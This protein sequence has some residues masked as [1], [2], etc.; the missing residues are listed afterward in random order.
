MR[1]KQI[2][3]L[4][5]FLLIGGGICPH[6]TAQLYIGN[7][8]ND[9]F[10]SSGN[11]VV[12]DGM[13]LTPSSN[14]TLSNT[15]I[16]KG[17]MAVTG[18]NSAAGITRVYTLS[19]S[20]TFTGTVSV[21]YNDGEL[22]GN[23][24]SQL[25]IAYLK[26]NNAWVTSA[27][28]TDDAVNNIVSDNFSAVSFKSL[29]ATQAGTILPLIVNSFNARVV[30]AAVELTW[31][32]NEST[33]IDHFDIEASSDN[34]AWSTAGTIQPA[35]TDDLQNYNYNDPDLYF[36][37]RYYRLKVVMASQEAYYSRIVALRSSGTAGM[38]VTTAK[39]MLKASFPGWQP[40]RI[41][42]F[43]WQGRLLKTTSLHQPVWQTSMV[44]PGIY[45][46]SAS[47]GNTRMVRKILIH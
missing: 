17:S 18:P 16:T 45:L 38:E 22:N 37:T 32:A 26:P 1:V 33:A 44:Q 41:Q 7:A 10:I 29:T 25:Q 11:S 46:L 15:Q 5:V 42:L 34:N 39:G 43:D 24:E 6:V 23:N 40:N 9:L 8:G 30:D 13:K 47:D 27:T 2:L 19:N 28:S 31:Q 12:Y 21:L 3:R 20:I 35:S 4:F 14:T 36:T